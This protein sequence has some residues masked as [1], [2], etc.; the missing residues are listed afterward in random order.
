MSVLESMGSSHNREV[1]RERKLR[2]ATV[3]SMR[4]QNAILGPQSAELMTTFAN[5]AVALIEREG[6]TL[7]RSGW[8]V[9]NPDITLVLG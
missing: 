8:M 2:P 6:G 3:A 5:R 9:A 7:P 1:T 4:L